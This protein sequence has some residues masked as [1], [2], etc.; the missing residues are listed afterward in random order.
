MDE[1][2]AIERVAELLRAAPAALAFTG[3]GV[4]T[5]SGIPDYRSP[6]G[7]WT[8]RTPPQ[9]AE[10]MAGEAGRAAYWQYYAEFY[11][12]IARAKPG[13]AHQALARLFAAGRIE[14]VITQNIDGLH[15]AAG[16][17]DAAVWELHGN[18]HTST[19]LGCGAFAMPTAEALAQ[20]TAEAAAPMCPKCGGPL[21]PGTISFGQNLDEAVL[22]GAIAAAERA[23]VMIAAGSSLVVHPAA[24]LPLLTMRRGGSLVLVNLGDTPLDGRAAVLL[25]ASVGPALSA[26]ADALGA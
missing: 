22:A 9:F 26:V 8:D 23:R 4:S 24:G 21:K 10:F 25:R 18:A 16:V 20:F 3:A 2:R 17:P 13:P 14:G 1:A 12:I 11:P 7:Q 6:G 19:C 5:E 15:Q